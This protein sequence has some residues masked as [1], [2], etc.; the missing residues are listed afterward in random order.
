MGLLAAT[1]LV[2]GPLCLGLV[3]SAIVSSESAYRGAPV[4][5]A[6]MIVVAAV[7]FGVRSSRS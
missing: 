5:F 2:V 7:V 4:F 6:V 1:L 3:V